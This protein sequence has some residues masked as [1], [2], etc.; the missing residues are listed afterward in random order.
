M[1]TFQWQGLNTNGQRLQGKITAVTKQEAITILIQQK[2]TPLKLSKIWK[3]FEFNKK[4]KSKHIADL[5]HEFATL[6]QAGIPLSKTFEILIASAGHD[7]IKELLQTM[8]KNINNGKSFAQTL[9]SI[10]QHFD[11][12]YCG[13]I[14]AAEQSG[15]LV[16]IFQILA[17]HQDRS[18]H[19][20]SKLVKAL[21]YPATVLCIAMLICCGLLIFVI[22]QFQ[23]VYQGFGASMPPL[24]QFI[25]KLSNELRKYGW[26]ISFLILTFIIFIRH[27][28][29]RSQRC[30]YFWQWLLLKLPI[31]GPIVH[32]SIINRFT[33]CMASMTASSVPLLKALKISSSIVQNYLYENDLKEVM[34]RVIT[35]TAFAQALQSCKFF[36]LRVSQMIAVGENSGTLATMLQK[37]SITYQNSLEQKLDHLSK[38]LEPVIMIVLAV[39]IGSLII[40]L[41]L[42]VFKLGTVI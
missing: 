4:I 1:S 36:P 22:P 37:V 29:N 41:Y 10:P 21:I 16:E 38:L 30:K 13:L 11:D 34:Q 17:K 7:L 6:L 33:L 24:T 31:I 20:Q 25:I 23:N 18:I 28:S 40:A 26:L 3:P 42:P 2:I 5:T 12:L 35:G 14:D 15:S 8:Q 9:R 19:F 39:L 27:I 32:I